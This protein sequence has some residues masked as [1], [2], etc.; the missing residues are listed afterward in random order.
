MSPPLGVGPTVKQLS[1]FGREPFGVQELEVVAGI[2][3]VYIDHRHDRRI[4]ES[5]VFF[6][7]LCIPVFLDRVSYEDEI[8]AARNFPSYGSM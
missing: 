5:K 2:R 4:V 6:N 7:V 3:L 8:S 1:N